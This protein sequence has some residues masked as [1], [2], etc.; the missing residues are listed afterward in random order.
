MRSLNYI[1]NQIEFAAKGT[2]RI[3]VNQ[4]LIEAFND[5]AEFINGKYTNSDVEDA[6]M[7]FHLLQV[8]KIDNEKSRLKLKY[9][10]KG[11]YELTNPHVL[12]DDFFMNIKPK[13]NLIDEAYTELRVHQILNKVDK[14]DLIKKKDVRILIDD[15]L[16][17]VRS[18]KTFDLIKTKKHIYG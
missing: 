16:K 12:F 11:V 9:G 3:T 1:K 2:G 13:E 5:V 17:D 7:L 15:L 10:M 8:W 18:F 4:N 6:L 14:E